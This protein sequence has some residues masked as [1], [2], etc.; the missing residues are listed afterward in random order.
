[1]TASFIPDREG[2]YVI[3]LVVSDG[4]LER[5]GHGTSSARSTARRSLMLAANTQTLSARQSSW[6]APLDVDGDPLAY[7]RHNLSSGRRPRQ[8]GQSVKVTAQFTPDVPGQYLIEL[9]V[10]DGTVSSAPDTVTIS[11]WQTNAPPIANAGPDLSAQVEL[12]QLDDQRGA[13]PTAIP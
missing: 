4:Q 1:M 3:Q 6:T 13:M 7:A 12:V 2:D 11:T 8:D 9:T 10:D 5:A